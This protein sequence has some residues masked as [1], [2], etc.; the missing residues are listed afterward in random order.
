MH[1]AAWATTNVRMCGCVGVLHCGC[2]VACMRVLR[3][4]FRY[5]KFVLDDDDLCMIVRCEID[6]AFESKEVDKN[7][8]SSAVRG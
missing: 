6:A 4:A 1:L 7:R 8:Y 5:Q 2:C 3:Q